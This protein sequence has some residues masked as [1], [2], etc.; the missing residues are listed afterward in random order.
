MMEDWER[1]LD[2]LWQNFHSY[3][4]EDLLN[5]MQM[6]TA[7]LSGEDPVALFELAS[8][9]DSTGRE[10]DAV[11]LYRLSL[12]SGLQGIRRRR[13]TIQLASTLRNLGQAAESVRLLEAELNEDC[14]ELNDELHAFIALCL[15]AVGREKEA[16]ARALAVLAPHLKR[17]DRSLAGYADALLKHY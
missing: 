17:Y 9:N 11:L 5:K 7:K 6:L 10:E 16:A 15:I 8:A 12:S 1:R 14:S 3:E 2:S 13:A 4:S